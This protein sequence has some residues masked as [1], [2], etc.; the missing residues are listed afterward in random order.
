MLLMSSKKP[1]STTWPSV[2]RKT[3]FL[4]SMPSFKYSVFSSSRKFDSLYPLLNVIS[5]TWEKE[6]TIMNA[7]DLF[8]IISIFIYLYFT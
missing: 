8:A 4:F 3:V 5:N 2:K 1:S 7:L 6:I